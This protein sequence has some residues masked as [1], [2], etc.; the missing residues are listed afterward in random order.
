MKRIGSMDFQT[1]K[2]KLT[3]GLTSLPNHTTFKIK[4]ASKKFNETGDFSQSLTSVL[5]FIFLPLIFSVGFVFGQTHIAYFQ[6]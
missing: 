6:V 5:S 1:I 4:R 3:N 2:S